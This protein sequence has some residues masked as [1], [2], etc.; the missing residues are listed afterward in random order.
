MPNGFFS[1]NRTFTEL[2]ES[3]SSTDPDVRW[4]GILEL[5]GRDEAW[6]KE[7]IY[8]C[9]DDP[10]ERV[11]KRA[12]HELG[13]AYTSSDY[14]PKPNLVSKT[15]FSKFSFNK[16]FHENFSKLDIWGI[17]LVLLAVDLMPMYYIFYCSSSILYFYSA[18]LAFMLG[19]IVFICN[20]T[21]FYTKAKYNLRPMIFAFFVLACAVPR[22]HALISS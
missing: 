15:K 12:H 19:L 10:D 2:S 3:L 18:F 9:V 13:L 20:Q 7:L 11:A 22:I 4:A 21:W 8:T 17:V 14:Q 16:A 5:G 6:A 1:S